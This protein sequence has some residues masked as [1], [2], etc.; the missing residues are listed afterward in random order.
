MQRLKNNLKKF[1]KFYLYKVKFITAIIVYL[2]FC[3]LF[4]KNHALS[5]LICLNKVN[6]K[7]FNNSFTAITL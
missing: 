1:T 6:R 4:L 3:E 7:W 5:V 2:E